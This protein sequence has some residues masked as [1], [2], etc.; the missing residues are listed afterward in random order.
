MQIVNASTTEEMYRMAVKQ[1]A[2]VGVCN[3][4]NRGNNAA[5]RGEVAINEAV[6]RVYTFGFDRGSDN[7]GLVARVREKL[8]SVKTVMMMAVWCLSHGYGLMT[9]AR[10]ESYTKVHVKINNSQR[11]YKTTFSP[12]D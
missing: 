5:A 4:E 2:S 7:V 3:W 10:C 8:R 11:H 9:K 1:F 6:I 12:V